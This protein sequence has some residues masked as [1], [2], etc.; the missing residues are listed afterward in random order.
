MKQSKNLPIVFKRAD[1]KAGYLS[2]SATAGK[3]QRSEITKEGD[4]GSRNDSFLPQLHA[5]QA[6]VPLGSH[7]SDTGE[8]LRAQQGLRVKPEGAACQL[9]NKC[10][11]TP[12]RE[13]LLS[14]WQQTCKQQLA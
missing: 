12:L 13:V 7:H 10:A 14:L 1:W 2:C 3:A 6:E 4:R 11:L 9:S 5:H 8:E